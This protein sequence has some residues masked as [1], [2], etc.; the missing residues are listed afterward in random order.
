MEAHERERTGRSYRE[1]GEVSALSVHNCGFAG[2]VVAFVC[3]ALA[4]HTGLI[5]WR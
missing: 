1:N 2:F 4:L 3:I 5:V